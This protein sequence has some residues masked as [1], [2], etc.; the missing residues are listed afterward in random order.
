MILSRS[1]LRQKKFFSRIG[2]MQWLSGLFFLLLKF[3]VGW[4][5]QWIFHLHSNP[6]TNKFSCF[7]LSSKKA[8]V[9]CIQ[10]FLHLF[11]WL[12]PRYFFQKL[13]ER[14]R[15]CCFH[16]VLNI[17]P[18]NPWWFFH[19]PAPLKLWDAVVFFDDARCYILFW[20][21]CNSRMLY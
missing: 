8:F 9:K 4:F 19:G 16:P 15:E 13:L 1:L 7:V 10:R 11:H 6:I 12:L 2:Y 20:G 5:G 3:L 18:L 21:I 14:L 17:L